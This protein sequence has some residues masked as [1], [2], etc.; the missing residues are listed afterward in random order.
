MSATLNNNSCA[1]Q[2]IEG[3]PGQANCYSSIC[4][5]GGISI[6]VDGIKTAEYFLS[7]FFSP[8]I[9][10]MSGRGD[11]NTKSGAGRGA[12]T[13]SGQ[14]K[15]QAEKTNKANKQDRKPGR[16]SNQGR[17][18]SSGGESGSLERNS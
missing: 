16:T 13:Q 15:N 8:K 9:F 18:E 10:N 6:T 4:A 7:Y 11:D 3:S 2:F 12:S 14:A 1:N 5:T 17:K